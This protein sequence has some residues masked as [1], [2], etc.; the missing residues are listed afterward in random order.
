MAQTI[1]W[2][3]ILLSVAIGGVVGVFYEKTRV[4]YHRTRA[5]MRLAMPALKMAG[6]VTGGFV[7]LIAIGLVWVGVL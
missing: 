6:Y 3:F 2:L 7:F 5:G 4:W 1:N